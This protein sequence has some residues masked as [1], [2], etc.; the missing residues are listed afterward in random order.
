[1]LSGWAGLSPTI[2]IF[3]DNLVAVEFAKEPSMGRS[4]KASHRRNFDIKLEL[5][6]ALERS[7]LQCEFCHVKGHQDRVKR[8][9]DMTF[10]E[11]MN[12]HCDT[13]AKQKAKG[14][15]EPTRTTVQIRPEVVKIMVQD[16]KGYLTG[17]ICDYLYK[18]EYASEV[19]RLLGVDGA[20]M[21]EIDWEA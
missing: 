11:Q 10:E 9:E 4:P 21:E 7:S 20:T 13:L 1:M 15:V 2:K 8:Y 12:Y 17:K 6:Q 16:Q 5:V 14:L 18:K 3:S 19:M